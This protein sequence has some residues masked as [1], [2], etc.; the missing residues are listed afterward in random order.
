[1]SWTWNVLYKQYILF[2]KQIK[3]LFRIF[4][5]P[6]RESLRLGRIAGRLFINT[7]LCILFERSVKIHT[8]PAT[9]HTVIY[10]Q[11]TDHFMRYQFQCSC[12][13][14]PPCDFRGRFS[15]CTFALNF[16]RR[17]AVQ[18]AVLL[19]ER[20]GILRIRTITRWTQKASKVS[21][22]NSK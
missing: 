6:T 18:I 12:R 20:G 10:M 11:I 17:H 9:D 7:M 15:C 22:Q 3:T 13:E 16:Y 14:D 4:S 21:T 8:C 19:P 2:R 5:L 1:M